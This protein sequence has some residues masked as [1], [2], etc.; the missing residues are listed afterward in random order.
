M[1]AARARGGGGSMDVAQ[2]PERQLALPLWPDEARAV[3][4]AL[5]RGALFAVG[6]ERTFLPVL[7]RIESIDGIEIRCK[8]DR[9]NQV[10]LDLWEALLHMQRL[11][12]LGEKITFTARSILIGLGRGV[13]GRAHEDLHNGLA[14]LV[15]TV[16]EIKLIKEKKV[17][18][19]SLV[20]SFLRDEES[21]RYIV[22]FNQDMALLYGAGYTYLDL[23][24]RQALTQNNLAKWLHGYYSSHARPYPYLVKT[25]HRL[26]GSLASLKEFRRLLIAAL[27]QLIEVGALT[28]WSIEPGTDMVKVSKVATKSQ[29]RHLVRSIKGRS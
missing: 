25:L 6:R 11:Q 9:L 16:M 27:S 8:N 22:R 3:P 24:Q 12:P 4:N 13:S 21:G 18:V 15:G 14:R 23:T 26:C 10:D 19:G 20:S 29:L 7:T 5:L 17:F 28:S 1:A 2:L